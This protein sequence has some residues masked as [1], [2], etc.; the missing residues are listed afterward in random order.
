VGDLVAPPGL[1]IAGVAHDANGGP[2]Q[3]A[4]VE[5]ISGIDCRI[6]MDRVADA[7]VDDQGSFLLVVPKP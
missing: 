3:G 6:S 7:V 5:A 4:L 1:R 2:L